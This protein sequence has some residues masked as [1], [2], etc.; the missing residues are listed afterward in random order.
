MHFVA[1]ML[2]RKMAGFNT[3]EYMD[4]TR[5]PRL[6]FGIRFWSKV[7]GIGDDG[8]RCWNWIGPLDTKGYGMVYI[9]QKFLRAHRV[10]YALHFRVKLTLEEKLCHRC[11]NRRCVRP[12][13]LFVGTL[14]DNTQDMMS[15]GRWKKPPLIQ[16]DT[17]HHALLTS[18]I[19]SEARRMH[20]EGW[21]CGKLAKKY[22]VAYPT[23]KQA[24]NRTT[25]KHVL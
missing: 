7:R 13:H 23:M 17:H 14:S 4:A 3:S 11:D 22:G 12:N 18:S 1:T 5:G 2:W 21:S 24:V 10:S 16:G 15:K 20:A 9:R 8:D 25:W 6:P 19:V